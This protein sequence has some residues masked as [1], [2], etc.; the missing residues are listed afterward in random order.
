MKLRGQHGYAMTVLLISLSVM[1]IMMTVVMPVWKQMTQREKEAELAFRGQQYV[2]AIG[3]FQRKAGPGVYPPNV[4]VLVQQHFLRKKYKDPI[5]GDDF[6]LL[7]AVAAGTATPGQIS[8]PGAAVPAGRGQAPNTAG[9]TTGG[10]GIAGGVAGVAS[11]SKDTSIRIYNGRTHYNEWEFRFLTQTIAPAAGGRG[12]QGPGE[13]GQPIPGP[14]GVG[15]R[16]GR[17]G[18]DGRG[19]GPDGRG[20]PN[21]RGGPLQPSPFPGGRGF[22]FPPAPGR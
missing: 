5:T 9:A 22:T 4:D 11:K 8:Q 3:L 15:G 18:P 14:G 13:G 10:A 17:G 7:P 16:G 19:G 21:G 2:H 6:L 12:R 20:G 1:A